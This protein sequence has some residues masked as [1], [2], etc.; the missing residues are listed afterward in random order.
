M[1]SCQS[2]EP[3]IPIGVLLGVIDVPLHLFGLFHKLGSFLAIELPLIPLRVQRIGL[4][5]V[6]Y[7]WS[8]LHPRA[9]SAPLWLTRLQRREFPR[10]VVLVVLP[11]GIFAGYGPIFEGRAIHHTTTSCCTVNRAPDGLSTEIH[12][13]LRGQRD[14]SL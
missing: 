7:R 5:L 6:V 14:L 12:G 11:N 1:K 9:C 2:F 4:H 8:G 3:H 10:S 13:L